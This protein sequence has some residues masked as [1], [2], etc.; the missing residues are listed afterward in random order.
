MTEVLRG[1][2]IPCYVRGGGRMVRREFVAATLPFLK[3]YSEIFV[4]VW[5]YC[6]WYYLNATMGS[7][8]YRLLSV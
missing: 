1:N 2:L 7:I 5:L 8:V 6:E 4:C 3:G